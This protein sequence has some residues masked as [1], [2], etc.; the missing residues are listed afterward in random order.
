MIVARRDLVNIETYLRALNE[1][2]LDRIIMGQDWCFGMAVND[3]GQR[4]LVGHAGDYNSIGLATDR[5]AI[6]V[7][8]RDE[9]KNP[10]LAFD[11]VAKTSGLDKA[12]SYVKSFAARIADEKFPL[13]VPA[14]VEQMEEVGA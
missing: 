1:D 11:R 13:R 6:E 3:F 14:P 9:S 4:C 10:A 8:C 7:L 2:Q 5:R 12:V